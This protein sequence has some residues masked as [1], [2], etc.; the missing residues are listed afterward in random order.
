MSSAIFFII[1]SHI[2]TPSG[3]PERAGLLESCTVSDGIVQIS[4]VTPHIHVDKLIKS[5]ISIGNGA[6]ELFSCL[7]GGASFRLTLGALKV[8]LIVLTKGLI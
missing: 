1:L 4:G 6:S 8:T 5:L 2:Y 3:F 7:N